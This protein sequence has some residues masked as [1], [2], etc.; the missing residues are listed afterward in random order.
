M[1]EINTE[2]TS[3]SNNSKDDD[4]LNRIPKGF[5]NETG[6]ERSIPAVRV[7]GII[8]FERAF[9]GNE[10]SGMNES[11][12]DIE[13]FLNDKGELDARARIRATKFNYIRENL[14]RGLI[15]DIVR[16]YL[17]E[18][19]IAAQPAQQ[20]QPVPPAGVLKEADVS[21]QSYTQI[22]EGVFETAL[23]SHFSK[24]K[25]PSYKAF[26]K[27]LIAKTATCTPYDACGAC[28][29]CIAEGAAS[30]TSQSGVS[31]PHN[32]EKKFKE[33]DFKTFKTVKTANSDQE[34]PLD[35]NILEL[36]L[37]E[38]LV[39]NRT[40]RSQGVEAG[41][42]VENTVEATA[43]SEGM[44]FWREH[45]FSGKGYAKTTLFNPTKLELAIL[46]DEWLVNDVRR[47]AKTSSGAGIWQIVKDPNGKPLLVVDEILKRSGFVENAPMAAMPVDVYT[48]EDG[49]KKCFAEPKTEKDKDHFRR[50][51]G[52]DALARLKAYH[53][54]IEILEPEDDNK[55]KAAFREL[56]EYCAIVIARL[57]E[58]NA[59]VRRLK[60]E[61]SKVKNKDE[62]NLLKTF[63]PV[64]NLAGIIQAIES[65]DKKKFDDALKPLKAKESPQDQ[66]KAVKAFESASKKIKPDEKLFELLRQALSQPQA[67]ETMPN[68]EGKNGSSD[69][70][71][72]QP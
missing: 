47:G 23:A 18:A 52:D 53:A 13:P 57:I 31:L 9:S 43:S 61:F 17:K 16:P 39:R 19:G 41:A 49:I 21:N 66:S 4:I 20:P 46:A 64:K 1:S 55:R 3:K 67:T 25:L 38:T 11:F 36:F 24:D 30:T 70:Q 27:A 8:Q 45:M 59:A 58:P 12:T 42:T 44:M 51:V 28:P 5:G 71:D 60:E 65:G 33:I 62:E 72:S 56:T 7:W 15:R 48:D 10:S 63:Q 14:F 68:E 54:N 29:A 34:I 6:L 35:G 40:P 32:W 26:F 2:S 22:V 50:Y 37:T 69:N